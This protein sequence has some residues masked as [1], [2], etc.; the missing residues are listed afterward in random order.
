M[1]HDNGASG[2]GEVWPEEAVAVFKQFGRDPKK[3]KRE[4]V[5]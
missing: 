2:D 1:P 4:V 3:M 5:K